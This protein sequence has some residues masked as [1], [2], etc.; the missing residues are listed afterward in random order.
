MCKMVDWFA[1]RDIK[2]D[3][4]LSGSNRTKMLE[5]KWHDWAG[6]LCGYSQ[7]STLH[8]SVCGSKYGDDLG[9]SRIWNPVNIILQK[10]SGI[11][12]Q[13]LNNGY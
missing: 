4:L 13:Y 12:F 3:Q 2:L 10:L 8:S 9:L 7:P 6:K 1:L 5:E 11:V